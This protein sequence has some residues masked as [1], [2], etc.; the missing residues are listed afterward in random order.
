MTG[1]SLGVSSSSTPPV[2]F[3]IP[4][5]S[6]WISLCKHDDTNDKINCLLSMVTENNHRLFITIWYN[7]TYYIYY[8]CITWANY[9]GRSIDN[10]LKYMWMLC[11]TLKERNTK[12]F[13]Q[14]WH[15]PKSP[16]TEWSWFFLIELWRTFCNF[17]HFWKHFQALKYNLWAYKQWDFLLLIKHS[18]YFNN[19]TA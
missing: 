15:S 9:T 19:I 13:V 8:L 12:R 1:V 14:N 6:L 10:A 2:L 18:E 4:L 3:R 11:I 17:F 5:S 16:S 7:G